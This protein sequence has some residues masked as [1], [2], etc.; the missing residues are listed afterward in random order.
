M[1]TPGHVSRE[2]NGT[3]HSTQ[4]IEDRVN[5][6]THEDGGHPPPAPAVQ[7][8]SRG[9]VSHST[10]AGGAQITAYKLLHT[11]ERLLHIGSLRKTER[12]AWCQT[13]KLT[14]EHRGPSIH[15]LTQ[16]SIHADEGKGHISGR[17]RSGA[18]GVDRGPAAAR[19]CARRSAGVPN[20]RDHAGTGTSAKAKYVTEAR[21]PQ[22][23]GRSWERPGVEPGHMSFLRS[24][25]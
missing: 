10:A 8:S 18:C 14:S 19:T 23:S 25:S 24:L 6:H 4:C 20:R 5:R 17:R 15:I 21:T 12:S 1:G 7:C 2:A 11:C 16:R 9:T 22:Q 13:P 3:N